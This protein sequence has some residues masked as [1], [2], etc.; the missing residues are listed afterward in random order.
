MV[1][2]SSSVC[3]AKFDSQKEMIVLYANRFYEGMT[4]ESI[5]HTQEN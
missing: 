5:E 1:S 4:I 3:G 2:F